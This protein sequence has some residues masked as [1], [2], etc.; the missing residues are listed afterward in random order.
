MTSEEL[1][2]GFDEVGSGLDTFFAGAET[3]EELGSST[4]QIHTE[5]GPVMEFDSIL[6]CELA[7]EAVVICKEAIRAAGEAHL[8]P[9][10]VIPW[11][12]VSSISIP[13]DDGRLENVDGELIGVNG[14]GQ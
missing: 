7:G 10:N 9:T 5:D 1:N 12:K 8:I 6:M 13:M 2:D 14:D 4:V 11:R 3:T